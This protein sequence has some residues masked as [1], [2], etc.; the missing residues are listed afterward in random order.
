MEFSGQEYGVGLPWPPPGNFLTQGLHPGL[1][2]CRLIL[3]HLSYQGS[4]I[5]FT[6][7]VIFSDLVLLSQ[8][9]QLSKEWSWP[10]SWINRT[11]SSG[12]SPW[13]WTWMSKIRRGGVC[14]KIFFPLLTHPSLL[15]TFPWVEKGRP[16]PWLTY[17]TSAP[18]FFLNNFYFIL[19]L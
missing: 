1:L 12:V 11:P 19:F 3:H 2:H 17:R 4:P 15:W 5:G 9:R 14:W 16:G 7:E 18:S 10:S 8:R 13:P 6:E